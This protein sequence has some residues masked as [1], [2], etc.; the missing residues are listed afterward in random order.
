MDHHTFVTSP[1]NFFALTKVVK[2]MRQTY[3]A[4]DSKPRLFN[5]LLCETNLTGIQPRQKCWLE[6]ALASN[7]KLERTLD[8]RF[9]F[10]PPFSNLR[11]S[12]DLLKLLDK[13]HREGNGA[14][15]VEDVQES[16]PNAD[17]AIKYLLDKQDVILLTGVDKKQNLFYNDRSCQMKIN[18]KYQ[19][20]WR[21][22]TVDSVEED[23]I[24]D[25]LQKHGFSTMQQGGPKRK[26]L[27]TLRHR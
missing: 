19:H 23:K 2:H 25:Y 22:V 15:S 27:K 1:H 9:V 21:C 13:Q 16:L 20:V 5:E 10:L 6:A 17:T 3:L 26:K 24:D 11:N 8:G 18:E 14:T 12:E 7:K 4:G